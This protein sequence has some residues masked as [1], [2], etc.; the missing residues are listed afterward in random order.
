VPIFWSEIEILQLI[1][2][3]EQGHGSWIYNGMELARATAARRDLAIIEHDLASFVRELFVLAQADLVTWR[4]PP[5]VGGAAQADPRNANEYLHRM[6]DLALTIAG[7]DRARGQI[8]V[9]PLPDPAEDDGRMIRASTLDDIAGACGSGYTPSQAARLLTESGVSSEN[10]A[11]AG[12][13][14]AASLLYD[15]FAALAEGT[16]GQ[17][18]ELR[19]FVGAW[20]D[21]WLHTGPTT[22][23]Q[24]AI[25]RDLARQGWFLRD[26]RL[27]IGEPVRGAARAGGELARD[28]RLAALHERVRDVAQR[29]FEAGEAGSAVFEACKAINA[30]VKDM[31]GANL[32]GRDLM[33]QVFRPEAPQLVL[34]DVTTKT[35]LS[36]QDGYKFLFMGAMAAIRNPH[37]HEPS[38]EL[39]DNEALEQ[40]GLASLLMRRLDEARPA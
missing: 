37:A 7:R 6:Q 27:V 39:D 38:G 11:M 9:V 10:V 1:D 13:D 35:G 14:D 17:R 23:I 8:V 30:R 22:T 31:T 28:A 34:A 16:S 40:L 15:V 18:R 25:T 29:P 21:N 36:V 12:S 4:V 32:D 33:G 20:L 2:G 26:G 19:Q 24:Q 3:A 5:P